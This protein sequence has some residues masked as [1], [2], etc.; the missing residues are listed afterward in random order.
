[1]TNPDPFDVGQAVLDRFN[2]H[3]DDR[4]AQGLARRETI[5]QI[6]DAEPGL[7]AREVQAKLNDA[8]AL[9]TVQWHLQ[10]IHATRRHCADG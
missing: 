9:R 8:P 6:I 10:N 1:M 2:R 4:K 3:N 7:T 5:R